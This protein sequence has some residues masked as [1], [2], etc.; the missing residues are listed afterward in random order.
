MIVV[1]GH[2]DLTVPTLELVQAELKDRLGRY[3]EG[4]G[5]L[6][7]AGAGL[8]LAFGRA[9]REA[10]RRLVVLLPTERSVPAILPE[11][12]RSAAAELLMMAEH[13]R[14]LGFDPTDLSLIQM[15]IRD[16]RH[17]A[18]RRTPPF[19]QPEPQA[20]V[21]GAKVWGPLYAAY[22]SARRGCMRGARWASHGVRPGR[23]EVDGLELQVS[24]KPLGAELAA[25]AADLDAAERSGGVGEVV[26][27]AD[28]A[29]V[30]AAGDGRATLGVALH[31]FNLKLGLPGYTEKQKIAAHCF[32]FE[33]SKLFTDEHGNRIMDM[34]EDWDSL[35]AFVDE[36]ENRPWPENE[37]GR[38]VTL[39]ILDQFACRNFPRPLHGLARALATSTMHPTTWRVHGMTPPPRTLSGPCS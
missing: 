15:C 2:G 34:P 10:G 17:R 1:V 37:E 26:V 20:S 4:V 13:V 3:S 6:V 33:M 12:D 22:R 25:H 27:E 35:T 9:V 36:F 14:L 31:R 16:R 11:P 21:A 39:A 18:P 8:H 23:S 5:G 30:D 38:W 7:R 19:R 32:W 24:G 28:G 29:G